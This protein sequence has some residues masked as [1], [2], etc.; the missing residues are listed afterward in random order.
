MWLTVAHPNVM[1]WQADGTQMARERVGRGGWEE[2]RRGWGRIRQL[3]SSRR[4][5]ANYV[6][7]DRVRHNALT[8]FETKM[9]AEAWL[10]AERRS[11]ERDEWQPPSLRVAEKKAKGVGVVE[12]A[13]TWIEQRNV[14]PRTRSGYHDLLRLHIGP[15]FGKVPL[16]NLT[17]ETVRGWYSMLG[18][19]HPR[20]NSHAYGLLHAICATAVSDGLIVSNPCTITG[21]MN[22]PRRRDPVI[23]SVAE[24]A[25]LADA[26]KP[27]RLKAL[28]LLSAWCSVRWG[29]VSELRRKDIGDDCQLL[30]VSRAVTRRDGRYRVDTPLL[31]PAVT[32]LGDLGLAAAL[33]CRTAKGRHQSQLGVD[34]STVTHDADHV[35]VDLSYV[36]ITR[37]SPNYQLKIT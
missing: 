29:E 30:Y 24:V 1:E 5:Q 4:Y 21:V 13:H 16:K 37:L 34:W 10:A 23:L 26:I 15:M 12:Y 31:V 32:G 18:T 19:D 27:D 6:G 9:D 20:R 22:P 36:L 3:P 2:G 7:P 33:P 35:R 17:R 11:I 8:T 25:A 14:K 28:V